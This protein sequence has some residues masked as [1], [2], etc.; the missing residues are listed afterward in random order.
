MKPFLIFL[1]LLTLTLSVYFT[2]DR[3]ERSGVSTF[4][5]FD[6]NNEFQ[7]S[8]KGKIVFTDDETGVASLSKR[9]FLKYRNNDVRIRISEED[10]NIVYDISEDGKK[11]DINSSEGKRLLE[12]S[13]K[14]LIETGYDAQGRAERIYK[15]G[16]VDSLLAASAGM[17]QD[18][19]K[20][21][22]LDYLLDQQNIPD[23]VYGRIILQTSNFGSDFEK[24][25]M[26]K[27]L[28]AKVKDPI[29]MQY[30]FETVDGMDADFEKANVIK[31]ILKTELDSTRFNTVL[32][33]VSRMKGDFEKSGLLRDLITDRNLTSVQTVS[34]L[35]ATKSVEA[36]FEKERL[37]KLLAPTI[38][39]STSAQSY[40]AV[41]TAMN[42]DF[43]KVK[44]IEY[45]F[46]QPVA[47]QV[48][49]GIISGI[50]DLGGDFEKSNLVKKLLD[51]PAITEASFA[52][53]IALVHNM[54]GDF[55][56]QNLLK[57]MTDKNPGTDET[58]ISL[59][60]AAADLGGDF[61]KAS[62][63]TLIARKMP[64]NDNIR[65]AYTRAA[66]TIQSELEYGKTLKALE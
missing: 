55:E 31:T 10:G 52:R 53:V 18:H 16:G 5:M 15:K 3:F 9:G 56:K 19:I 45:L 49:P 30:F 61:E 20:T 22:Y 13:I 28:S 29:A 32:G 6:G 58:W 64:N 1:T 34:L 57:K 23:S 12:L 39:D 59:I 11:F 43:E 36:D 26:L 40:L 44:A 66:K 42:S 7:V 2:Y 37:L 65:T 25:K 33:V 35:K 51:G 38:D 50:D 48:M 60:D 27:K 46:K 14:E 47:V 4:R 63:L 54:G 21:I 8:S 17:K 24:A 62:L 41:V